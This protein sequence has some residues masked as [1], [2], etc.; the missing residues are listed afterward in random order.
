MRVR[1]LWKGTG[2]PFGLSL[3]KPFPYLSDGRRCVTGMMKG[4]GFD[5]LSPN[6]F[7]G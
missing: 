6:G 7:G 5:R 4:K 3:S 1:A 2:L